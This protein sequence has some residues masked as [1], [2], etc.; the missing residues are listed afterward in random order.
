MVGLSE[1]D[2]ER[3]EEFIEAPWY[4]KDPDILLPD[5]GDPDRGERSGRND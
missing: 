2:M 3:I 5:G 4:A 1:Q